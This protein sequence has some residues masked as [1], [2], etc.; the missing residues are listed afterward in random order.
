MARIGELAFMNWN[1]RSVVVSGAAMGI[2]RYIALRAADRGANVATG[3]IEVVGV[4]QIEDELRSFG[5]KVVAIHSDVQ[6]EDDVHR[7]IKMTFREFGSIDYLV[8]NAGIV[9]HFSWGGPRWPRIKDMENSLWSKVI[10]T[11]ITGAFLCSKH[12]IPYMERQQSGHIVNL[13]GGR[14]PTPP[15]GLAYVLTKKALVTF[16]QY[17]AE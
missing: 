14:G 12:A 1:G 4:Q 15:G 10:N 7:L 9:P 16:S 3:D 2:G 13:Y 6:R 5:N 17:L 11:N 8:N